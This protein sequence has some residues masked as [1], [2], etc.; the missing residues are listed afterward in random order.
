MLNEDYSRREFLKLMALLGGGALLPKTAWSASAAEQKTV[1]IG[2]L[3]ITDAT[4]LLVAYQNKIFQRQGLRVDRPILFRSWAQLIEAFIAGELNVIHLL[5]PMAVWA[6][7]NS[8]VAAKVVAWNHVAGSALT[9]APQIEQ[10]RDL[11]GKRVAIPFWYSIHNVVLQEMLH[12]AGLHIVTQVQAPLAKHEVGLVVLPPSD[13]PPALLSGQIAG[14][15]VAEPFNAIAEHL[16]IGKILRF[17]GDVWKQHACCV[18]YMHEQDLQQHPQWSQQVVSSIVEAQLWC[19]NHRAETAQL[20]ARQHK[21]RLT[22]HILPVLQQVLDPSAQQ[23]RDYQQHGA[24]QHATWHSQRID[25]QPY[26]YQSYTIEL[27]K[28]MRYTQVEGNKA[29]LKRLDP[30]WA[31]QQ[32]VDE[33]FVKHAILQLGGMQA[34]GLDESFT[35]QEVFAL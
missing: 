20:L 14:Y 8:A 31:A 21:P 12:H 11:G 16:K 19:R 26:P 34:F 6:R 2:Y 15:L 24:I 35:R 22:P 10:L 13:M 30:R 27:I 29:F 18:V 32:L 5:S 1:R 7:F 9:V 28:R 25:F 3:P 23:Q 17:T 33:R 4:P